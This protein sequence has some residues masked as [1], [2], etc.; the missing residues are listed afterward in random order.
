[1]RWGIIG[2]GLHAASR[3][4]PALQNTPRETLQGVVGSTHGKAIE[5]ADSFTDCIAYETIDAMLADP[6]VEAVFISTPNDQ[7]RVQTEMAAAAGKHVLVE[8]PMALTSEDCRAMIAACDGAGVALGIGF[9]MRH[10]P[11]HIA[12]RAAIKSGRLGEIILAR[13]EWHTAYG[14]WSNWRGSSGRAGSDILGAVGVH[15]FDLLSFVLDANA[16]KVTA[17]VDRSAETG[18][19]QTIATIVGYDTG[20]VGNVTITNRARSLLNSIHVLGTRGSACG[21]GTVG[22]TP[23][24][25]L[26]LVIDGEEQSETYP[27]IDLYAAQFSDF[28]RNTAQGTTVNASGMDGLNSVL[29]SER[30]LSFGGF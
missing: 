14:P 5:F 26:D 25:R 15:V 28:S 6:M 17:F 2:T 21:V 9:Q 13:S 4:A 10:A 19:D 20:A 1:M 12:L 24:G 22:M 8:K 23:T 3:I 18:M 30:I 7:H 27:V 29:L 11:V 16:D